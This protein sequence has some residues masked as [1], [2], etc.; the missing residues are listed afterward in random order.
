[1]RPLP[2]S[3]RCSHGLKTSSK[4]EKVMMVT[5]KLDMLDEPEMNNNE[6]KKGVIQ[7]KVQLNRI[8]D[9]SWAVAMSKDVSHSVDKMSQMKEKKAEEK[10]VVDSK[11]EKMVI[12]DMKMVRH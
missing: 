7:Y 8:A 9:S 5:K 11:K 1:L 3:W 2:R 10:V 12:L 4:E 6:N